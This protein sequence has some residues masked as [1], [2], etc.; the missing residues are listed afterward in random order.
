MAFHS[1]LVPADFFDTS[2]GQPKAAAQ[3]RHHRPRQPH[4][5]SFLPTHMTELILENYKIHPQLFPSKIVSSD[6]SYLVLRCHHSDF[7]PELV[8]AGV[9][10]PGDKTEMPIQS[11]KA[12]FHVCPR[13]Q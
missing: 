7:I 5:I 13:Y 6:T 11:N 4:L 1:L 3:H 8:P 10:K 9:T 12:G 2:E